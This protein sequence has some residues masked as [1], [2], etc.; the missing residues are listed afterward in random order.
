MQID[1]KTSALFLIISFYGMLT[2]FQFVTF[3]S[4]RKKTC[5]DS[6]YITVLR[7]TVMKYTVMESFKLSVF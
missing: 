5:V 7:T 6:K 4:L 1:L 3:F 2:S